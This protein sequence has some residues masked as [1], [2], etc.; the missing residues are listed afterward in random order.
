MHQGQKSI[1]QLQH[2]TEPCFTE[3]KWYKWM[4]MFETVAKVSL[5]KIGQDTHSHLLNGE[6]SERLR[7][8]IPVNQLVTIHEV[9]HHLCIS[10]GSAH[11]I[12]QD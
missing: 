11:G 10:H 1:S 3:L 5:I 2:N 8:M 7:A 6:N 4:T 12:I 9:V